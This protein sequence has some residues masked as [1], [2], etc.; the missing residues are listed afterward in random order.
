MSFERYFDFHDKMSEA[1]K[2]VA[3]AVGCV[4]AAL[5][6]KYL[7]LAT[8]FRPVQK[9][10]H[11]RF[12]CNVASGIVATEAVRVLLKRPGLRPA[13]CYFQYDLYRQKLR[14][15]WL[16]GGTAIPGKRSNGDGSKAKCK[17]NRGQ[18]L[19]FL[20]LSALWC[21]TSCR[22]L[23]IFPQAPKANPS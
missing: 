23:R 19:S 22:Q 14:K 21:R 13:P 12:A 1:D 16:W 11:L 17:H 6:L 15:G 20:L 7:N 10:E 5:H 8:Y 9:P 18:R 3:F 4:P 2:I